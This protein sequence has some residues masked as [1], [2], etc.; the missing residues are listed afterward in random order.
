MNIKSIVLSWDFLSAL[1]IAVIIYCFLP[2]LISAKFAAQIYNIGV[3]VLSIVF[4]VFFA[5]LAVIIA[6]PSDDFIRF[7][8]KNG[9]YDELL[10]I[11][12]HTL[13]MLFIGL[14]YSIIGYSLSSFFTEE[15]T[16]KFYQNKAFIAIFSFIFSYSLFCSF[17]SAKDA[18]VYSIYRNKFLDL[19]EIDKQE[20][21]ISSIVATN[22]EPDKDDS[23]NPNN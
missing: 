13:V 14:F 23:G 17:N 20:S 18:I 9:G 2:T 12:K 22:L 1:I 6:A 11:F 5:S 7:F 10:S 16:E 8:N 3:S 15:F 19:K 4:S 21:S